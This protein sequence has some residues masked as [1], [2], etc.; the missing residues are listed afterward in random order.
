MLRE[1]LST[2]AREKSCLPLQVITSVWRTMDFEASIR[3]TYLLG[4]ITTAAKRLKADG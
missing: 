3:T 4:A 2:E 1:G